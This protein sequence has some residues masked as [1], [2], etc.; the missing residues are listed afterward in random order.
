M[1]QPCE[2][3]METGL[4]RIEA[5]L[6]GLNGQPEETFSPDAA[7]CSFRV[8]QTSAATIESV[9]SP[10]EVALSDADDHLERVQ[11]FPVDALPNPL[12]L[13]RVKPLPPDDRFATNPAFSLLLLKEIQ[14]VVVGWE[15]D[16][17]QVNRQIKSVYAEGPIVDGWLESQPNGLPTTEAAPLSQAELNQLVDHVQGLM[18]TAKT[19]VVTQESPRAGYRLCGLGTDGQLWSRPCPL[20][21]VPQV[22]LAIARHQK[23]RQLLARKQHLENR[24]NQL[25]Q[26]LVELHGQLQEG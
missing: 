9:L 10:N 15:R 5:M 17:R 6:Q 11:P 25:S 2:S 26:T 24:L 16:L 18:N 1:A 19:Q 13:P 14:V 20:E 12:V 3:N 8:A 23:L 21:Q 4:K 7:S 22:S